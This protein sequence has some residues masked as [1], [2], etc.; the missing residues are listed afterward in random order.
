LGMEPPGSLVAGSAVA[1]P[2]GSGII[3]GNRQ[4]AKKNVLNKSTA[5]NAYPL[6]FIRHLLVVHRL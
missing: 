2:F 1:V 4:P 3:P 5:L 6:A